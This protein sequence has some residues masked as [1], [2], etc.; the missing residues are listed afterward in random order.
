MEHHNVPAPG[1]NAVKHVSKMIERVVIA[2]RNE[3]VAGT[4]THG[5]RCQ[6][7]FQLEIELIHLD[8][9][10]TATFTPAFRYRE[11]DIKQNGKCCARHGGDGLGEQVHHGDQ[12][13]YPGDQPEPHGNLHATETEIQR[14]LKFALART[15]IAENEDPE[16]VHPE[17]PHPTESVE[18]RKKGDVAA[19]DDDGDNLECHDGINDAIARPE[20]A[21][22]LTETRAAHAAVRNA[23]KHAR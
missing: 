4:R 22:R 15:A 9:G 23:I 12:K 7:R 2:D 10:S 13:Q 20:P 14:N 8:V 1:L 3:N 6:F 19:A 18:V 21:V 11:Y 16:P 17:P 5:S